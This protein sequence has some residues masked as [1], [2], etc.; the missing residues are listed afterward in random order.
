MVGVWQQ[1]LDSGFHAFSPTE[2]SEFLN[3]FRQL[4]PDERFVRVCLETGDWVFDFEAMKMFLT[5]NPKIS[6]RIRVVSDLTLA[7]LRSSN[8]CD[9]L[10]NK[11]PE[12][13][14]KFLPLLAHYIRIKHESQAIQTLIELSNTSGVLKDAFC[15]AVRANYFQTL[16]QLQAFCRQ[17]PE[18][19]EDQKPE[20]NHYLLHK[21]QLKVRER[22]AGDLNFQTRVHHP[23]QAGS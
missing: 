17:N 6:R 21:F 19:F 2:V 1:L 22:F 13:V 12:L 7:L 16:P 8:L 9:A 10:Q 14:A 3:R 20:F 11:D 5:I 15:D 23:T 4:K 18:K